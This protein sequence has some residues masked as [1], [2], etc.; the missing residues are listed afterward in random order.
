M[1]FFVIGRD[2]QDG[3]LLL[4]TSVEH[5]TREEAVRALGEL[6]AK[7]AVDAA[8]LDVYVMDLATGTPTLVVPVAPQLT[9]PFE[10][11][12]ADAMRAP[13]EEV[14]T[15]AETPVEVELETIV[16]EEPLAEEAPTAADLAD[17]AHDLVADEVSELASAIRRAAASLES[18]IATGEAPATGPVEATPS[19]VASEEGEQASVI[20]ATA[21]A[22]E[23]E[24]AAEP[25]SGAPAA[26]AF[27]SLITPPSIDE[28]VAFRPVVLGDYGLGESGEPPE[29]LASAQPVT[30]EPT[31]EPPVSESDEEARI[32][33]PMSA[34][35]DAPPLAQEPVEPAAPSTTAG[36]GPSET[37]EAA[38]AGYEP[39]GELELDAYTCQ[40]CMYANT[41]PK[42]GQVRPA[43]CGSFQWKAF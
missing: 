43:D 36:P 14:A 12:A 33:E 8:R 27:E 19:G 24:P 38:P 25:S 42:V 17:V 11:V 29:P 3:S 30:P 41:C 23:P 7:G 32:A 21:E 34:L 5:P 13:L 15:V 31:W 1:G 2:V 10:R 18:E 22:V 26:D 4:L 20:D 35:R 40:D 6:A 28:E 37:P 9:A 16:V 39:S